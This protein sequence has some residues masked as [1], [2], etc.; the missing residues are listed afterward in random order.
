VSSRPP[1]TGWRPETGRP[2]SRAGWLLPAGVVLV[3]AVAGFTF[4]GFLPLPPSAPQ[5]GSAS[6]SSVPVSTGRVV[7]TDVA[8]RQ[9]VSGTLGYRGTFNVS[10][11][12]PAGI[13]TW[14]PAAGQVIRRGQA[15]YRIDGQSVTLL[16]GSVPAW[17]SFQPGM[18]GG[19]DV[20]ELDENLIA[21]GFDPDRQIPDTQIAGADQF[22]WATAAAIE[23]WQRA[24][25]MPETGSIPLGEV[26]FLPGPL[27]VSTESASA[28]G[29]AATG[30]AVL[31]GTSTTPSV[32]V[33]LTPG[34]PAARPG[35]SVLV[36]LPNGTTTVPGT[37][38]SVGRVATVPAQSAAAAQGTA[39]SQGSGGTQ[40]PQIP[41]TIG[42]GRGSIDAGLDQAPVQVT[43]TEAEDRG[44][45]AVPITAL[46]ALPDGTY[47]VRT[48]GNPSRLIPVTTGLFDDAAGLVEVTGPGLAAGLTIE[49]AQG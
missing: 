36:T 41:V 12:L 15:L 32:L 6:A 11:E 28:G 46:L 40:T 48:A 22:G 8:E 34:G 20:R 10:N 43:I 13:I 35:D 19:A 42:L 45:L 33:S 17:R 27:L 23:L 37:V 26:V 21:L 4:R 16:Y 9:V 24:H 30:T 29:P 25:G 18:T 47:A 38:T 1:E 5:S 44:V 7:R 2:G 31:G 14:L 3:T 39:S 49:V